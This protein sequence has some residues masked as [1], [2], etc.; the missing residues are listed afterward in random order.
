MKQGV[1]A[2]KNGSNPVKNLVINC[3]RAADRGV[4]ICE[5]LSWLVLLIWVGLM[6]VGVVMR[7][8]FSAPILFQVDLVS[9]LL[10]VFCS[11]SFASVL[12][13]EMHIRVD[14]LTRQLGART[15]RVLTGFSYLVTVL[16]SVLM[17]WASRNLIY[18]SFM[19]NSKFDVSGIVLWPFQAAFAF[20]FI[21]LGCAAF[22]RLLQTMVS[23][24]PVETGTQHA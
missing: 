2:E 5:Y 21:L 22:F 3:R 20:G 4:Q 6:T 12:V 18:I 1:D 15:Q 14:I 9:G 19:M 16:L 23:V 8:V 24:E 11:F 17:V 10:V 7:Y 13:R